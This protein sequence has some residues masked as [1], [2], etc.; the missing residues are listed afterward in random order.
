LRTERYKT[1]LKGILNK[2]SI[3]V[4]RSTKSG[5][6]GLSKPCK[7]CETY[8]LEKNIT[9]VYYTTENGYCYENMKGEL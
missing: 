3:F 5:L 2:C 6:Q 4:Y 7:A 1:F 9:N 8:L